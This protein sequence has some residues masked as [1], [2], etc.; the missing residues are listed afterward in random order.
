MSAFQWAY[1]IALTCLSYPAWHNQRYALACLWANQIGFLAIYLAFDL[2]A[3]DKFE[4]LRLALIVDLAT[5]V[6]MALRLGLPAIIAWGYAVTVPIYFLSLVVGVKTDTT[7]DI[8]KIAAA[9][10][11]GVFA[12]GCGPGFGSGGGGK[13]GRF[14]SRVSV[15]LSGRDGAP[16]GAV[17]SRNQAGNRVRE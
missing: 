10:Q 17:L 11:M 5:G 2:G 8:V 13:R 14:A 9:A 1:L 4:V 16:S 6:A 7:A 3:I 12:I 15:V